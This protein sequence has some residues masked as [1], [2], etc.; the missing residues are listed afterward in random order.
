MA[1]TPIVNQVRVKGVTYNICDS[2]ARGNLS[3]IPGLV[4]DVAG[5]KQNKLDRTPTGGSDTFTGRMY[6]KGFME[7]IRPNS[8]VENN[9]CGVVLSD[10][11]RIRFN[12]TETDAEIYAGENDLTLRHNLDANT[13]R[14]VRVNNNNTNLEYLVKDS[15]NEKPYL[16]DYCFYTSFG[17][18]SLIAENRHEYCLEEIAPSGGPGL[19]MGS[20]VGGYGS[21]PLTSL[22]ITWPDVVRGTIFGVNF[23]S[24]SSFSGISHRTTGGIDFIPYYIGDDSEKANRR[25]N[26]VCWYDGAKKWCSVKSAE[27]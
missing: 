22:T 8:Y 2:T 20:A 16:V 6:V 9:P 23:T 4:T 10:G 17:S 1:Q 24:G 11:G 25:Y 26:I 13:S 7:I 15:G 12:F 27:I 19:G 14:A 21:A 3:A 18:T 5:L